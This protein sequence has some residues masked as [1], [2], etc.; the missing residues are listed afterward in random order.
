MGDVY[1]GTIAELIWMATA[2]TFIYKKHRRLFGFS[3]DCV[4]LEAKGGAST[5]GFPRRRAA[6]RRHSRADKEDNVVVPDVHC[7]LGEPFGWVKR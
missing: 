4:V 7:G 1:G 2:P 3:L 5:V 6:H